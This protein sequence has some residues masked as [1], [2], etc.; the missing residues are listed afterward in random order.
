M[1][2]TLNNQKTLLK[3]ILGGIF[4][5]QKAEEKVLKLNSEIAKEGFWKD[6]TNSK[7]IV[8]EKNFIESIIFFIKQPKTPINLNDL[9]NLA[10]EEKTM[11]L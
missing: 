10:I 6:R 2:K 1:K 8:R 5:S 4:D 3:R 7:K 9:Y 11:K